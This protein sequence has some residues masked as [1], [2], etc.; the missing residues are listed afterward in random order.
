MTMT[1]E[2]IYRFGFSKR[3]HKQFIIER[4]VMQFLT[5]LILLIYRASPTTFVYVQNG[6][7]AYVDAS[8]LK[9]Y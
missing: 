7:N 6:L 4:V 3:V 2:E 9:V 5:L 1:I 8:D